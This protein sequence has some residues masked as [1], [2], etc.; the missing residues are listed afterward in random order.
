MTATG[1][2]SIDFSG[3]ENTN[4][5]ESSDLVTGVGVVEVDAGMLVSVSGLSIKMTAEAPAEA[6]LESIIEI[7]GEGTGDEAHALLVNSSGDGYSI[8]SSGYTTRLYPITGFSK[9]SAIGKNS[10]TAKAGDVSGI[11]YKPDTGEVETL[12]NGAVVKTQTVTHV[13]GLR[14]G[15]GHNPLNMNTLGIAS[16]AASGYM[17]VQRKGST[18]DAAHTLGTIT[19]A[20]LNGDAIEINSTGAGTVNL[21]DTS[22]IATSGE[23][24]LVLG[25]GSA[26][27]TY[28]M[29]INV[30]GMPSFTINKDGDS[31]AGLTDVELI[32]MTGAEG[33]RAIAEQIT[34]VTTDASGVTGAIEVTNASLSAD[35]VV[36]V[37]QQ[38]A[39][40]GGGLPHNV[41]LV[42]L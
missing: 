26:T 8:V 19:S 42:A 18:F 16:W 25:D 21:T 33:S 37:V 6:S 30:V 15:F 5:Y 10:T 7:S 2:I 14:A 27:E 17:R 20:T 1:N 40:V 41:T 23:Y 24:D 11:R 34:G 22:G 38:S 35:D 12:L 32:V 39:T 3:I 13:A 28:T 29:Q 31:Q 36:T 9:G 4:P